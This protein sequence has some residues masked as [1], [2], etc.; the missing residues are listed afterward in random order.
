[1]AKGCKI[2]LPNLHCIEES[3]KDFYGE[4]SPYFII[5]REANALKNPLYRATEDVEEELLMC[6]DALTNETQMRPLYDFSSEPFCVLELRSEFVR[7]PSTPVRATKA[8]AAVST[9]KKRRAVATDS[10]TSDSDN[11]SPKKK[12]QH[13][14]DSVRG[15]LAM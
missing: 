3:L 11:I 1:L 14:R 8:V 6:P 2:W 7:H 12:K 13:G 15:V 9:G 5:R 4:L 10:E